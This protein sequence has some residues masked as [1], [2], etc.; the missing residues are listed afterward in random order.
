[1]QEKKMLNSPIMQ[2]LNTAIE[3]QTMQDVRHEVDRLD[4]ILVGLIAERQTYMDAAARIKAKREQ[5]RDEARIADVIEKVKAGARENGLSVEIAEPVWRTM[6]E[7]CIAY[8]LKE[9]DKKSN[10]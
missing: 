8:E 2:K 1:M 9:F 5:V 3:C 7:A 6:I 4:Q 10:I